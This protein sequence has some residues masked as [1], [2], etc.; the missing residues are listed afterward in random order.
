MQ[1]KMTVGLTQCKCMYCVRRLCL[2]RASQ[3]SSR[4]VGTSRKRL[5][6]QGVI[7]GFTDIAFLCRRDVA[8]SLLANVPLVCVKTVWR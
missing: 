1:R 8:H 6:I 2:P 7:Y 3:E 4:D 5:H